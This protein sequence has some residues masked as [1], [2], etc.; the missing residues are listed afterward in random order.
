MSGP[1]QNSDVLSVSAERGRK[2]TRLE[3]RPPSGVR[4]SSI[5]NTLRPTAACG[6]A[7][8]KKQLLSP[9]PRLPR[10]LIFVSRVP[11]LL[12]HAA[13]SQKPSASLSS[14]FKAPARKPKPHSLQKTKDSQYR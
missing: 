11:G 13:Q 9:C 14:G 10:R 6:E 12:S 5:Q 1:H 2:Q 4:A 3:E 7:A 8:L